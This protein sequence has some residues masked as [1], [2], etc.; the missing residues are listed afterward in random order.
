VSAIGL[1]PK[2]AVSGSA[3]ARLLQ[4]AIRSAPLIRFRNLRLGMPSPLP[5]LGMDIPSEDMGM[6]LE[7]AG[8]IRDRLV[9]AE[10]FLDRVTGRVVVVGRGL[11]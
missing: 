5:A 1:Q 3:D 6:L 8:K 2:E 4:R 9:F 7:A 11:A 10:R